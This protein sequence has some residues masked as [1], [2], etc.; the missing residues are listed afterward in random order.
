VIRGLP[1][2]TLAI[3]A[4]TAAAGLSACGDDPP[5]AGGPVE[6]AP[7]AKTDCDGLGPD[8]AREGRADPAGEGKPTGVGRR[9]PF[10]FNDGAALNGA[11]P[12]GRAA[13]LQDVVGARLWR[14]ALDWRFAEPS[15]GELELSAH[16]A[17][18]CSALA[19]GI[20][21]I[22]HIT[23]APEWA[24]DDS[25]E[26]PMPS[27]IDPP[28]DSALD[29][30]R[31]FAELVA[32]RYPRL[33][34]IEAWNEPNL[35]AFWTDPDPARYAS[36]LAAI[37][38]GVED[39]G[40]G[41]P[42]LGASLSNTGRTSAAAGRYGFAEFLDGIYAAG[43]ADHMDAIS[44]HPYPLAPLGSAEERFT[45]SMF[46][47]RRAVRRN[48]DGGRPIWVTEVGLPV[49]GGVTP[50][51]Q[52]RTMRGVYSRLAAAGDVDAVVFH[53]LLD[54]SGATGT[55]TGFGWLQGGGADEPVPRLVY[56]RFARQG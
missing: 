12:A 18:Y 50:A 16:D 39:A 17:V 30:L 13:R 47:L 29:E 20:R 26:C 3:V 44:F 37:D 46:E 6:P 55:G 41:I 11:L 56:R 51:E 54:G 7:G 33:A 2:P 40:G 34:A 4:V 35:A 48:G 27:C 5:L 19:R 9:P 1:L 32:R 42:V 22:F 23:G 25:A 24:A 38:G 49:G 45:A 31:R 8:A 10:G 14:V 52:A 53:T 43:A 28:A 15:P 21:P 36:V